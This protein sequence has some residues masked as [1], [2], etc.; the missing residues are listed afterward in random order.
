MVGAFFYARRNSGS[1]YYDYLMNDGMPE[2]CIISVPLDDDDYLE[3]CDQ[4][5]K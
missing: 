3:Y 4:K 5:V 1:F 2:D